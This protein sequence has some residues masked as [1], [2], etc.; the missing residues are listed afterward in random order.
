MVHKHHKVL[1]VGKSVDPTRSIALIEKN[2]PV[3]IPAS[4]AVL[5]PLT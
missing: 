1:W 3:T 4:K 2:C 5:Q